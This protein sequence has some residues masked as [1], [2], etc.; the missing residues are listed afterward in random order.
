MTALGLKS[1]V[2]EKNERGLLT[3]VD[4]YRTVWTSLN[5]RTAF[6]TVLWSGWIRFSVVIDF[7]DFCRAN[8]YAL[9]TTVT[10]FWINL[11]LGHITTPPML[12]FVSI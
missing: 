5:T 1:W 3:N 7:K 8:T 9:S 6:L 2:F 4:G 11:Y 10:L 12:L